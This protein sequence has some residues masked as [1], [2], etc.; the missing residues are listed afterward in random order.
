MPNKVLD[1]LNLKYDEEA[2][3][4]YIP[5]KLVDK[6]E[7]PEG[8]ED[9]K[10][11]PEI[12]DTDDYFYQRITQDLEVDEKQ[13]NIELFGGI[14]LPPT[15]KTN[16]KIFTANKWGDIEILM[17]SLDRKPYIYAKK[18][19]KGGQSNNPEDPATSN[20]EVYDVLTRY[21]PD[22]VEKM[23][24]KYHI[25]GKTGTHPFLPPF[26]IEA[27]EK[28]IEID[29]LA[30]TEGAFKSWA[31]C[32]N[33]MPTIGQSSITHYRDKK[34]DDLHHDIVEIIVKC[35]VKNV[36]ILWD[37]DFRDVRSKSI[38]EKVDLYKRPKQFYSAVIKIQELLLEF[39]NP[40]ET[41]IYFSH[42]NTHQLPE[43]PKG[44]DDL[45]Q[46]YSDEIESITDDFHQFEI[47][48]KFFKFIDITSK[49]SQ[50][51]LHRY[52]KIDKV[53]NFRTFHSDKIQEHEFIFNGTT[54]QYNEEE[55]KVNVKVPA[56]AKRF[57]RVGDDFY[58]NIP[59]PDKYGNLKRAVVSRRKTTIS[60]NHG[61]DFFRHIS[62]YEAFVNIP[63][64]IDFQQVI[65]NC[66]NLYHPF[67]HEPE[68]GEWKNTEN[69][70]HHIFGDQYEYGLDYLQLLFQHPQQ[71]LPILCLV[72]EENNTGKSTFLKWE[73][74]IYDNNMAIVGN[75]DLSGDFNSGWASSLIVAVDEAFIEKKVVVEKIKSMSTADTIM[76]NQKS[77][78]L[79]Q[80][81][82]FAKFQL[83][84]NN[85]K[86]FI[87]A[88]E[89]DE[90]YW[91]RK[92]NPIPRKDMNPDLL[93]DML[94]E[95]PAF[96][97]F[98]ANRTMK[99]PKKLHRAWFLPEMLYTEALQKVI[100][101]SA[102]G[103]EKE[104]REEM[105]QL[106]INYE[107]E[108]IEM[109][110][111]DVQR[112]FFKGKNLPYIREI[113]EKN[114]R[115]EKANKGRYKYPP[116]DTT[117]LVEEPLWTSRHSTFYIFKKEMFL[118]KAE[119]KAIEDVKKASQPE[120]LPF[121]EN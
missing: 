94:D 17:Y 20:R 3:E 52:F 47:P 80:I 69:F 41:S 74:M 76:V 78:D 21:H 8:F 113:I 16:N 1:A 99:V 71:I 30:I 39:I 119:A 27:Y 100:D 49:A 103:L 102:P 14:N 26:L 85:E 58:K 51:K 97:Y 31:G 111:K 81:D 32:A 37:G 73:K 88:S 121:N 95:I 61:K 9:W 45:I 72:S 33:Q 59:K 63:G 79:K 106:F 107:L 92:I 98:I 40:K 89:K 25:T 115:A 65:H 68:Q 101:N 19:I 2:K 66:Y 67:E 6:I 22:R 15:Q 23:G 44:L 116:P 35:K 64:H 62:F 117:T 108:T 57:F 11:S 12:Y 104:F 50:K 114:I 42:I 91:V 29:T 84:T 18:L 82:F 43:R 36:V 83:V 5:F 38:I 90:R 34:T 60:D 46:V 120:T 7:I 28:T 24:R 109:N 54:Y 48:G 86:N 55:D 112:E 75:V 10:K 105:K 53:E 13:N 70:L 110:S 96:L 4:I 93:K 77:K 118:S 56:D 87:Y